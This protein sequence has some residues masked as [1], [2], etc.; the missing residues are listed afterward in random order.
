[1]TAVLTCCTT[2]EVL[3]ASLSG[4]LLLDLPGAVI[5]RHDIDAAE[6][7]LRRHQRRRRRAAGSHA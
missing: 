5:V 2:D 3:R 1:M 4:E 6:G 7:T